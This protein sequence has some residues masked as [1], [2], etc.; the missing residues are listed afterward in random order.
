MSKRTNF[1]DSTDGTCNA[2]LKKSDELCPNELTGEQR[3]WCSR[4]CQYR[5]HARVDW[6]NSDSKQRAW[7]KAHPEYAMNWERQSKYGV[8]PEHFESLLRAQNNKCAICA[9]IF[10]KESRNT[11]PC[12]DHCH[13]TN[14]VRGILCHKCNA[15]LGLATDSPS[16]LTYASEYLSN[17]DGEHMEPEEIKQWGRRVRRWVRTHPEE[18]MKVLSEAGR[19]PRCKCYDSVVEDVQDV[20]IEDDLDDLEDYFGDDEDYA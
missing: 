5:E 18:S 9:V 10:T 1:S 6:E 4:K 2:R 3:K 17:Y 8:T 11:K 7:R 16:I 15:L 12:L 13:E 19:L 20:V 14:K